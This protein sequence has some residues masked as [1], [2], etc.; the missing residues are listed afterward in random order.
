MK[1][2]AVALVA[3]GM[4][5]SVVPAASAAGASELTNIRT[6]R[7]AGFDRVVFDFTGPRPEV[8]AGRS[9]EP[10]HCGSG[11]P[12]SA[13]GDEFLDVTMQPANAN[14]YTGPR[15][16]DTPA[17][18]NVRSVTNTC[19]FEAHLGFSLGYAGA[20]RAY[21]ISFLDNPTR[22]VVDIDH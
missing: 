13:K 18:L 3:V 6:E 7:H 20:G 5:M 14:G 15:S 16:F 21:A 11:K 17:L 1:R 10:Y 12:I 9:A 19:N 8:T 4:A 2:I 22:V